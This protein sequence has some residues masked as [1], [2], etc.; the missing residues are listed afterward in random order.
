[1]RVTRGIVAG[2]GIGAVVLAGV[3]W[4]VRPRAVE[5]ETAPAVRGA[6]RVT[7]DAEGLTR[8][9]ERYVVAAPVTGRVRRI[10][11]EEGAP[12][13]PGQIVAWIAPAPLD[14]QGQRAAEARLASALAM[15]REAAV[16][17]DQARV[18]EEHAAL[19]ARRYEALFA[20]GGIS[21]QERDE[22][23][24]AHRSRGDDLAAAD[25]RTRAAAA[26]V[27]VARSAL[28][29]VDG[30][31]AAVAVRSPCAG[32]VLRVPER[33]E[34]VVAAGTPLLEVGDPRALEVIA[35]VLSTDAVQLEPGDAVEIVEWGGG[36]SLRGRVQQVEP[37]A[38]TRVSAL[39]V[40]EQRVNVR[41]GIE[42]PPSALG[43]GYRVEVRM[44][45]WEGADVLTVPASALFRHA[46]GWSAY[47]VEGRRARRRTI[48]LGHRTGTTV[49]VLGGLTAD[50]RVILFPSDEIEDGVRV[51]PK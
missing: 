36:R 34:R 11:L 8:V 31:R 43:D 40:D 51:T 4:A 50:E 32:S 22:V 3:V 35:D 33:S 30:S 48:E 27:R 37:S 21:P 44:T 9:R 25:A 17:L 16:R 28:V 2:A 20:A 18:A 19:T 46:G 26:E 1:M 38:F 39:G 14:E 6:M 41:V 7:V 24:L 5:V 23:V 13:V 10:A 49:E 47:V 42:D 12:V 45:V 15:Q 29:A